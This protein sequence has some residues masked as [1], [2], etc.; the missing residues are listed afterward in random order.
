MRA[1]GSIVIAREPA[2]VFAY[3]TDPG[4]DLM[5]RSF[6]VASHGTVPLAVGSI[7][8]QSY[9]Y[10]GNKVDVELEVTEFTP[11]TEA[12]FRAHGK[13][14]VRFTYTCTPEAGGTRFNMAGSL[15]LSGL[16]S[17]FEGRIQSELDVAIASDLKRL[18]AALKG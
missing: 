3:V 18:K 2:E 6:L 15:E 16:A 7:V 17:M 12:A 13:F 11:P 9:S 4:N 1:R 14:P 5:W 10:Q 8:R